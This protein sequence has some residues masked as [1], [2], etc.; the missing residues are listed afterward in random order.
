MEDPWSARHYSACSITPTWSAST[1]ILKLAS[2]IASY[3]R[4]LLQFGAVITPHAHYS[5]P[6]IAASASCSFDCATH[7]PSAIH[8]RTHN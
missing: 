1:V 2:P 7:Q 4:K 6:N 8:N 3:M 5:S